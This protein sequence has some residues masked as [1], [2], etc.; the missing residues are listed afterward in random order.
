M[1]LIISP[2]PLSEQ[3]ADE[4]IPVDVTLA[5]A[6]TSETLFTV[7]VGKRLRSVDFANEGLGS[8]FLSF[9]AGAPATT[10]D[11]ELQKRDT[12]AENRLDLAEGDYGFIGE[13]GKQ[14][15]VRGVVWVGPA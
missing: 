15:R 3:V 14:P 1:V 11:T 9:T 6:D 7:P 13:A 5:V 12:L 8:S 10:S 4:A 2:Q